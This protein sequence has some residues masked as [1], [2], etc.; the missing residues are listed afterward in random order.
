VPSPLVETKLYVPRPRR[1]LLARP[2]LAE[3]L[4]RGAEARLTLVSAPAG[5]GK[6]TVLAEWLAAGT[7][8][9]AWLSLDESDRLPGTFWTYLVTAL[10]GAAPGVGAGALALLRSGQAPI[11]TVLAALLN[12]L[13]TAQSLISLVLDDYHLAEGP[14]IQD[15]VAFLLEHL[16]PQVHVV[17]ST[18][19]DPALPLARLRARG[20]LVEVR[21]A[22]LRFTPE[23][24]AALLNENIGLNLTAAEIAVLERRTEGWIA[25]LQLAALSLQGRDDGAAFIAGFA[26]DDRYIVDYLVDEVLERQ[27]EPRRRFLIQTSVLDRLSGPLCDAV[28]EQSGSRAT[29]ASLDRANLFVVPLDDNRRWYRYHHLFA[30][31]LRT[32]LAVERPDDIADLHRR[33]GTWY[34]QNQEPVAAVRHALACGDVERAAALVEMAIP[35]LRMD[36]QEATIRAWIDAFPA[37]VIRVRPVLAMGFVGALMAAGEFDGVEERLRDV[38]RLL[39]PGDDGGAPAATIV[40]DESELARL[41]AAIPMYRAGLALVRGDIDATVGHAQS[42][43]DRAAEG[44]DLVRSAASALQGLA[45]WG[46]GDLVAAHRAYS[47]SVEG[48]RRAGHLS[49]VLGCSI[50]LAD[51]RI[52]QGRLTDALHTYERALRLS[53]GSDGAPLR[54]AA[55]MYV[56]MSQ[57]ACE[58]ND[59]E[60]ATRHLQR[61][62]ELGEHTWLPQNPYRWRVAMARVREAGGDRQGALDLLDEAQRV[63]VGDFSPNVRPIA[64]LRARMLA[65]QGHGADAL[66]WVR[67]CGVAPDDD[68]SYIREFEHTTLAMVLLAQPRTQRAER[69]LDDA[70]QLLQR[71]LHAAEAAERT[72]SVIEIMVLH[73]LVQQARGDAEA[74]L[75]P[76]QRAT[77]LAEPEGYVRVFVGHGRPMASL[78]GRLA[79]QGKPGDYVHRLVL[80]CSE[81]AS[82]SSGVVPTQGRLVDPLSEREM[83]VLRLLGSELSGPDIAR[84]LLVSLNTLRTHTKSIYAK[85]GVN[86]RRAAVRQAAQL[87]LLSR[88]RDT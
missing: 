55:D 69:P 13:G 18:R 38:E 34:E 14:D 71:L 70:A 24:V 60:S 78:L 30:D 59:L 43:I 28:T 53:P 56:G 37:E 10:E 84:E 6:T 39:E 2:R 32:H 80:A 67:E 58:R 73:G 65:A 15:D 16:P 68:L 25:A 82:V 75:A 3:R 79:Q 63:Y 29:L 77:T 21:A 35:T 74:A 52:T 88:S 54:G 8:P 41:P 40:V 46:S 76:L 57:I 4:S 36:R 20:E 9:V 11:R 12:E 19:A 17:I 64:A 50:T 26:G 45:L 62:R 7:R 61:A 47:A 83:D 48:L 49:D 51:I 31:V 87:R 42:A 86:S 72:G 81:P 27:S 44:D 85:L 5:F 1:S 23:E 33:A 22:D 66:A